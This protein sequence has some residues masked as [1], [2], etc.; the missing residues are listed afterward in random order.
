MM[1]GDASG[2]CFNAWVMKQFGELKRVI[3]IDELKS[4]YH[5]DD[6]ILSGTNE[7]KDYYTS[8]FA[9]K[10]EKEKYYVMEN[11]R[12][13]CNGDIVMGDKPAGCKSE[14]RHCFT[15]HSIQGETASH[16]LFIDS[17]KMFDSR[18]FYTAISRAKTLDQV[19]IIQNDAMKFKY[20]YAKIYKIV[21]KNGTYIGSTVQPLEKRF[22]DHK[23]AMEDYTKKGGKY[24]TS[25]QLLGDADVTIT[26]IETFRCNDIKDL[27]K[28]ES[29][30][31]QQY[32]R[33]CVNKT[34]NEWAE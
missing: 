29:E 15:T 19:F 12:L 9:G 18:M 1:T 16:N 32:G 13:Y 10:F 14:V 28:R 22:A 17:S 21:S 26:K 4:K 5:I 30:V 3:S 24:L 23:K 25:F 31:I 27:W 11:N 6:L 7:L 8:L 33:K 20:D 2:D 34:Y